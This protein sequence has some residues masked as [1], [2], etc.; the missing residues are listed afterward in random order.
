VIAQ[1]GGSARGRAF[2]AKHAETIVVHMKGIDQMKMYRDD[3]RRRMAECGRDPD[4]CKV[5]F[6]VAPILAETDE[7]ARERAR[8]RMAGAAK[9]LDVKLAQLGW[10][11]NIDFS[12]FDLDQP[13]GELTTNGHQQSL[14]Q[15]LRKAGKRTLREA[16]TE[17]GT[18][19]MS[20]DLIGTPDSVASQMQEVMQEV[21]GDGFLFALP[22]VNRRNVAEITDGLIP[23]L[24][25]RG[26]TRRAYGA[27]HLRDHLREF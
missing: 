14:A 24:Q 10:S 12:V 4:H 25:Q 26:L 15:F 2:A 17:Y 27:R 19:G 20:I 21:G 1:A 8:R 3:V 13:V 18:L 5:L 6:L 23:V 7:D 16:I 22:N 11:T 9:H